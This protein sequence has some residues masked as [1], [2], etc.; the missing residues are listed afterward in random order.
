M[1]NYLRKKKKKKK[2][3]REQ[4]RSENTMKIYSLRMKAYFTQ[5]KKK[6]ISF[7]F[8][9]KIF[10]HTKHRWKSAL[11]KQCQLIYTNRKWVYQTRC[12]HI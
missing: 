5:T 4:R 6:K 7:P 10:I 2:K 12:I 3:K 11:L 1:V 9:A 8:R